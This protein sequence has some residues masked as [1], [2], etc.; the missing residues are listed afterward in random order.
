MREGGDSVVRE[1]EQGNVS[2]QEGDVTE[3]GKEMT[4]QAMTS[5]GERGRGRGM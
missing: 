3:E 1:G 2:R 5:L 4:S